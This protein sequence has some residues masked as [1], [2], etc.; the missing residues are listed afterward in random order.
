LRYSKNPSG[1]VH[2]PLWLHN[3]NQKESLAEQKEAEQKEFES[4]NEEP[5]QEP[6]DTYVPSPVN[7]S[8]AEIGNSN[9]PALSPIAPEEVLTH[10]LDT[11]ISRL[12]LV[13]LYNEMCKVINENEQ[14]SIQTYTGNKSAGLRLR[15]NLRSLDSLC[16]GIGKI[17]KV[18]LP[19]AV[20]LNQS[21]IRA[22]IISMVKMLMLNLIVTRMT[23]VWEMR[24]ILTANKTWLI[25]KHHQRNLGIPVFVRM[26]HVPTIVIHRNRQ[27]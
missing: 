21:S 1:A 10:A 18:Q 4:I 22:R 14:E 23:W 11:E 7:Q 6:R 8:Q 17:L 5:E 13:R 9:F 15:R 25:Q 3:I 12:E 19:P 27:H 26:G 16:E 2:L 24:S 20:G